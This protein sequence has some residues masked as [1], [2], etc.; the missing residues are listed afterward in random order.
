MAQPIAATRM[1]TSTNG[2]F[3]SRSFSSRDSSVGLKRAAT[4]MAIKPA[5]PA[6]AISDRR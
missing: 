2:Q 6:R 5:R 4:V 1:T 3:R